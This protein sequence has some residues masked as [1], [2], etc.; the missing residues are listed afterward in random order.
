MEL[1]AKNIAE[2]CGGEVVSS[3][4][5]R[6][7][8]PGH[9]N[10]DRS[11]SVKIAPSASNGFVVYSH[12]G[13]DPFI[14]LDYVR[15]KLG[16]TYFSHA[17]EKVCVKTNLYVDSRSANNSSSLQRID[18]A[19]TIWNQSISVRYS[20]AETYLRRARGIE[21]PDNVMLRFHP[22]CPFLISNGDAKK[23][24]YHYPAMIACYTDAVTGQFR[25]IHRTALKP[26]GSGKADMPDGG[27]PK[28]I[29]GAS[30]GSIIRLSPDEVVQTGVGLAE[31]I[32]NGLTI[33]STGWSPVWAAGSAGSM[34]DFPVLKGLE[35]LTLFADTGEAGEKAAK[36]CAARWASQGREVTVKFPRFGDWNDVA[37]GL[38]HG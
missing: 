13:D 20:L 19:R 32:E 6:I 28:R 3:D 36:Q 12:A 7:P 10:K 1:T 25:A 26:D 17:R 11:L 23:K 5:A 38:Q 35:S 24:T 15:A 33:L 37:R 29:L 14:C 21:I 4:S 2:I 8:G 16:I 22:H 34:A 31:G 18:V 30:K 9:S 27:S